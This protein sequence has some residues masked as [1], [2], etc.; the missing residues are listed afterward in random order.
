MPQVFLQE[1]ERKGD[2]SHAHVQCMY[3]LAETDD[4]NHLYVSK[5][6]WRSNRSKQ[7]SI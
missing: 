4:T 5:R 6:G 1:I 3:V 2:P 7:M